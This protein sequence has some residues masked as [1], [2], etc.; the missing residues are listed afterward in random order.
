MRQRRERQRLAKATGT[1]EEEI[2]VRVL[3]LLDKSCLVHEVTII[4]SQMLE[5]HHPIRNPLRLPGSL[6]L[7]HRP[8]VFVLSAKLRIIL[9][10]I[11]QNPPVTLKR[12]CASATCHSPRRRRCSQSP[13][14]FQASNRHHIN[15]VCSFIG[16]ITNT[17]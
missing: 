8:S 17:Y 10:I 1:D 9:Y 11:P 2:L 13:L 4:P 16:K 3:D 12:C 15:S 14:I 6:L 5:V 7:A